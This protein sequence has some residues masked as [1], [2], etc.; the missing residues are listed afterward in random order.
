MRKIKTVARLVVF[1]VL[2]LCLFSGLNQILQHKESVV[3]LKPFLDHAQEYDVLFLGDSQVRAGILPMELYHSYGIASYNLASSNCR[4]SMSYWK[5][6]NALDYV[7]P[8]L[9]VLSVTDAERPELTHDRG[10]R[11]HEAFDA[12]PLTITKAR[13]IWELTDQDGVDRSGVSFRDIR[14]ELFPT[15]GHN[16]HAKAQHLLLGQAAVF[17]HSGAGSCNKCNDILLVVLIGQLHEVLIQHF[18]HQ[19]GQ[20]HTDVVLIDHGTQNELVVAVHLNKDLAATLFQ[21]VLIHRG[22]AQLHEN[23]L[24]DHIIGD[25][26]HS[27]TG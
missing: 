11:L 27:G 1:F 6:M 16:T 24:L 8:K 13:A 25:D 9:V 17:E 20:T 22:L 23:A 26:G 4:L 5:L 21:V 12:F 2:L 10:E 19:I 18:T 7:M 3:M 15:A 14:T